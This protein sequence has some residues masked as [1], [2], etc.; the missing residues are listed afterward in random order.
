[1]FLVTILFRCY[2]YLARRWGEIEWEASH[3]RCMYG[4]RL[5]GLGGGRGGGR[6]VETAVDAKNGKKMAGRVTRY[7]NDKCVESV[8]AI[9]KSLVPQTVTAARTVLLLCFVLPAIYLCSWSC[10]V[11]MLYGNGCFGCFCLVSVVHHISFGG[12]MDLFSS[13]FRFS[14]IQRMLECRHR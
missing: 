4:S 9:L 10:S 1:M 14:L 7:P 11:F 3:I 8:F 13:F 5:R 12:G 2:L 6:R